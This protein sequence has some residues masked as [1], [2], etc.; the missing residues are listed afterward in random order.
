ME[1]GKYLDNIKQL[2]HRGGCFI[3][4][5]MASFPRKVECNVCG[6]KANY[7]SDD[8]WHKRT[9]CWTCN[10]DVRHR[11]LIAALS[12]MDDL[13]F[14][15][16]VKGK[17]L[18]HFAPEPALTPLFKKYAK[19]HVT[20]DIGSKRTDMQLDI[21]NMPEMKS[22]EFE[23]LLAFDV[24]EHVA[25]DGQALR[26]IYRV[27]QHGGYAILTVPQ[28]DGMS[29]TLEDSNI[30]TPEERERIYGQSDHVRIYGNDFPD[31]LKAV[32]F[33][34]MVVDENSFPEELRKKYV[35]FPPILSR[36][37]LATN[38]RKIFFV[39]KA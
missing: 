22:D 1:S 24:L 20:A 18:L 37:P 32:G 12:Y 23:L 29:M 38:Y 17:K 15:K 14:E 9:I 13:S 8:S 3:K 39:H 36:H 10:S 11:L 2:F 16:L 19:S 21:S 6:A 30:A 25:D 31:L 33:S 7:F 34:V 27:L 26:E 28:K 35:L 4:R 5:K